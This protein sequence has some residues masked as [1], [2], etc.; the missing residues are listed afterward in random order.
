MRAVSLFDG[1]CIG[2]NG[3][4]WLAGWSVTTT[5]KVILDRDRSVQLSSVQMDT[6]TTL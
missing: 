4:E 1:A 5:T 6:N 3:V 2:G